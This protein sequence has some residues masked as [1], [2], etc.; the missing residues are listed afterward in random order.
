MHQLMYLLD[1]ELGHVSI[2]AP[3]FMNCLFD[4]A[5]TNKSKIK[6]K[7]VAILGINA[8]IISKITAINYNFPSK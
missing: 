8:T 2:H 4:L 6:A 5:S 3:I 1:N 7:F